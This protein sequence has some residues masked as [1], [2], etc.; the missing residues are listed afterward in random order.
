MATNISSILIEASKEQVWQ[1]LTQPEMV[2]EWQY[3]SDLLTAWTEGSEIRFSTE[4]QGKIFEQW[5]KVLEF[6]PFSIIRYSLFAPAPG[7]EDIAENYFIMT[8]LLKPE[9]GSI[10]LNIIQE[11]NRADAV[12]E[13][14]QGEENPLLQALKNLAESLN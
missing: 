3:G 10:M 13:E 2:K 14:P 11:D 8:Y 9:N 7:R 12:Q 4:W 5:G 6:K 1:V